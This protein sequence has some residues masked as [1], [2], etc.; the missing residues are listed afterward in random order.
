VI[1]DLIK[2]KIVCDRFLSL[3]HQALKLGYIDPKTLQQQ[4]Q[5]SVLSP[6][7]ANIVLHELDKF[8]VE[9]IIPESTK[10]LRRI[11][12]PEYNAIAY[13]RDP[14]NSK[15]S[16]EEKLEA[17]RLMR[18]I[19]GMDM[20]R[21]D[22]NYRRSMYIR[23]L[24]DFVYLFEGPKKEAFKLKKLIKDFLKDRIGLYLN[25]ENIVLSHIN[26]GFHFLG[27]QVK[28]QKTLD[29]RMKTRSSASQGLPINMRANV[30]ARV[31]VN[32]RARVN[33]IVLLTQKLIK[34][35]FARKNYLGKTLARAMTKFV[36][37]DYTTILKIYISKIHGLLNNSSFTGNRSEIKN[38]L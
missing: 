31:R 11:T 35:G 23:Y 26:D 12:N 3:V 8:L 27:A 32:V 38:L 10:G 28:T 29:F 36:N 33:I 18:N 5:G 1:I 20:L 6:L 14:K 34:E 2:N 37:L 16:I 4:Q 24:G 13:A 17:L 25:T 30:R 7:F 22:P 21:R 19:P 9:K 15:S